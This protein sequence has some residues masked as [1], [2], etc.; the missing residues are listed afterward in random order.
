[1]ATLSIVFPPGSIVLEQ[2]L[3]GLGSGAV[4]YTPPS[5]TGLGD[6]AQWS[7][8]YGCILMDEHSGGAIWRHSGVDGWL[9]KD[10]A[11]L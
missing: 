6:M 8:G 2:P 4:S 9:G 7:L 10:N 1:M 11:N 3:E 5:T